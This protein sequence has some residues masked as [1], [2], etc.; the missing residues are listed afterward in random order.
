[1]GGN[2]REDFEIAGYKR[3]LGER[4]LVRESRA[5]HLGGRAGDNIG[6]ETGT[7]RKGA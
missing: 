4:M 1:M 2:W 6:R 7:G 3:Q 5:Q